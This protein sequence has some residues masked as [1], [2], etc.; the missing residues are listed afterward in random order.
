MTFSSISPLLRREGHLSLGLGP[1][2]TRIIQ[3]QDPQGLELFAKTFF[4]I[5]SQVLGGLYFGDHLSSIHYKISINFSHA[6]N[7]F[8]YPPLV[9]DVTFFMYQVS[10]YSQPMSGLCMSFH[11][12]ACFF[13]LLPY[14]FYYCASEICLN[15]WQSKSLPWLHFKLSFKDVDFPYTS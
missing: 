11:L 8:F 9:C 2:L 12:S 15:I 10:M 3:S 14:C 13:L 6:A 7:Q 4:Q 1:I 5:H